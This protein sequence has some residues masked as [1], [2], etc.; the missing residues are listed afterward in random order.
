M[1]LGHPNKLIGIFLV[2]A[3][4]NL[5]RKL[6]RVPSNDINVYVPRNTTLSYLLYHNIV[7]FLD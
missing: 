3:K 7:H 2:T 1:K 4:L 6:K 5:T